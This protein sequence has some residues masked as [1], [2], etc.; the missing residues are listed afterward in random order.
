M[1]KYCCFKWSSSSS[2]VLN[3][4]VCCWVYILTHKRTILDKNYTY[5]I[6]YWVAWMASVSTALNERWFLDWTRILTASSSLRQDISLRTCHNLHITSPLQL[7]PTSKS[8]DRCGNFSKQDTYSSHP[9]LRAISAVLP[10]FIEVG[11]LRNIDIRFP[12]VST[13]INS[14]LCIDYLI[15]FEEMSVNTWESGVPTS[16]CT[17]GPWHKSWNCFW[18][19]LSPSTFLCTII[20]HTS[21]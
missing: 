1:V 20:T 17:R 19:K 21:T 7:S 2:R 13:L 18:T 10:C 9:A 4:Q 3:K 12:L 6:R 11:F 14:I 15:P 5:A 16:V 8:V